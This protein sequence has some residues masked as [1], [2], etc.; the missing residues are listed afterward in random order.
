MKVSALLEILDA[1]APFCLAEEWDR[2]GLRLGSPDAEVQGVAVALDPLPSAIEAAAKHRC[3]VLVTHHPLIF[4]PLEDLVLRGTTEKAVAAALRLDM[5]VVACHTCWDS[6][7]EGVNAVLAQRAALKDWKP[8]SPSEAMEGCGLGGS[9]DLPRAMAP[10]EAAEYL[11]RCWNLS[12]FR[13]L[14]GDDAPVTRLALCGGAGGDL[15]PLA[16]ESRSQLYAT[17]DLQYHQ[18]LEAL[19]RGLSLMVCDHGEMEVLSIEP[20]AAAIASHCDFP[21]VALPPQPLPGQWCRS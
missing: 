5:A 21:V 20:L 12:G 18:Y 14:S 11:A 6:A 10:M 19:D 8:L 13:L 16:L 4:R 1:I 17:A 2:C 7:A 15:W 9:G 3:N